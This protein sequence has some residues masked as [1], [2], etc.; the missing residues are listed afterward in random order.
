MRQWPQAMQQVL[1]AHQEHT[2]AAL[3]QKT[4]H[5]KQCCK[6]LDQLQSTTHGLSV[7]FC[8]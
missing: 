2:P 1:F 8:I 6:E 5:N 4:K 7:L 3:L